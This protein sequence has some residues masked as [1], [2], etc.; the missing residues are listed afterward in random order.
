MKSFLSIIFL[1]LP[2]F[3]L[4]SCREDIV[5]ITPEIKTGD[6]YIKSIPSGAEII[7]N[8]TKT[9]RITPDSLLGIQPGNYNVT[10]R[11]LGVGQGTQFVNIVSGKK[12]YINIHIGVE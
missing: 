9:G 10:V 3:I 6:L 8:E 7:F 5:E 12:K 1:A 2:I 11:I 4:M